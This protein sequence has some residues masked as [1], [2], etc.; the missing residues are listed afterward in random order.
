MKHQAAKLFA[1]LGELSIL[2]LFLD[3]F[4]SCLDNAMP[5]PVDIVRL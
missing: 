3:L 2:R 5:S 1:D 4:R